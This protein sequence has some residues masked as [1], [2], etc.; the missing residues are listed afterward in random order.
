MNKKIIGL[1]IVIILAVIAVSGCTGNENSDRETGSND[2]RNV[3]ITEQIEYFQDMDTNN[4]GKIDVEEV[5]IDVPEE[6]KEH[7]AEF[8]TTVYQE[9]LRQASND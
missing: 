7:V 3:N 5:T 9:Y 2:A 1:I 8:L 6:D 4:N